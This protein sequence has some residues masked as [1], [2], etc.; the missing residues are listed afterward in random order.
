MNHRTRLALFAAGMVASLA[1]LAAS[2]HAQ[3]GGVQIHGVDA[4][5]YPT[6]RLSVVTP[7]PSSRPPKVKEGGRDVAGF[8][9]A[10]LGRSKSV[11][12]AV[13][14]SRSMAGQ[15]LVDAANG[16]RSFVA[17]KPPADR[18]EVIAFGSHPVRLTQFSSATIDADDALRTMNV[19][20]KSGTALYDAIVLGSQ[21]LAAE[22]SAGRVLIVLTDGKDVSSKASLDKAIKAARSAGVAVYP[23]AIAGPD[24][25]VEPL[26]RIAR[27]TGGAYYSAASSHT[28]R[29]IYGSIAADLA[30]TWRVTYVTAARPGQNVE[31]QASFPGLGSATANLNV[32][33]SSSSQGAG[34]A[35]VP[36]SAGGIGGTLAIMLAVGGLVLLAGVLLIAGSRRAWLRERLEPHVSASS[37]RVNEARKRERLAAAAG[38]FHATERALGNLKHWR[39]AQKLLERADI[40]LRTVELFY[41][42]VGSGVAG[43]L[44]GALGRFPSWAILIMM[45]VG[46]FLPY[47]F[48]S[49]KAKSRLKAFENQLPD[50][51]I[52]VAASLKAGHSFRQGIQTLVDEGQDPAAGEFRR[53]LT[54]TQLGRPMEDAL[55]EMSERVGSKNFEFAI[56]AVT[57]QR[58]VGGSLAGLFDMVAD[59][60]RQRQQFTRKIR[61]LT[62]MGR[63]SAYVLIGLPFFI[64][65]AITLMNRMYMDPLYHTA[66]GH[67][68]IGMMLVL[69]AFGSL[70]LKKIVSFKG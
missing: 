66:K 55:L 52:T 28:L 44:V 11:V 29:R 47:G 58:Q 32:P 48:V 59:T 62:A 23:I 8:Q 31:L 42:M 4:S 30:R 61:S 65:G 53:V 2:G 63:M 14:W 67:F 1:A 22:E 46:A 45:L 36:V 43:G 64:A 21:T 60:V 5:N 17:A 57:I 39:S 50:L 10:A 41:I 69:M 9:A 6:V 70:I 38:L 19:D 26:Q 34:S 20:P 15:S 24:F 3:S 7:A 49:F 12:L 27:E 56:T 40:R 33:G 16:A 54:D 68:L 25:T 37:H 51:L 18:I 35:L 13:D